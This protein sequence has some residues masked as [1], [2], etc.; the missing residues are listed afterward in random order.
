MS[1]WKCCCCHRAG[2]DCEASADIPRYIGVDDEEGGKRGCCDYEKAQDG[3][4][5]G[6]WEIGVRD[7][8][9]KRC[10]SM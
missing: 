6:R 5:E 9:L 8:L 10:S 4:K 7:L 3:D 2:T 1:P